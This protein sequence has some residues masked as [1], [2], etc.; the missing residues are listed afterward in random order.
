MKK[1]L[2]LSFILLSAIYVFAQDTAP[3]PLTQAEYV[4]L[5]Y[6]LEKSP[7][8]KDEVIE[9]VRKRGIGFELTDGLRSL[10]ASKS[11]SD[12]D[13]RRTLE[14]AARRKADPVKAQLPSEKEAAEILDK[15]RQATMT[16]VEE[17]PD[18]VVKQLIAR[19]EAYA[20]T[21]NWKRLDNVAIAVSF[22][23]TKGEEYK[24]MAING[25]P[26]NAEKG[27]NYGGLSGSTTRG[28]FVEALEIV[29]KPESK[30]EF[31]F[32]DT[33]VVRGR[34][35]VVYNYKIA[36]ENNKGTNSI[37]LKGTFT[38][39]VRIGRK[40]RI[41]VDRKT[42]RILRLELLATDLPA[43]FDVKS[44]E[45]VIDYDWVEIGG[46]KYLLPISADNKFTTAS[47][48]QLFQDR[49]YIRF[50]DYQKYGSEVRILDD[51]TEIVEEKP[52][53]KN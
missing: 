43:S 7:A 32:V 5:L 34:Q 24:V 33:D 38:P 35:A 3:K 30:T 15:A 11:R 1:V 36:L 37:A 29:F 53:Q 41:W 23:L 9:A 8:K 4:K 22:S 39:A 44:Y 10:T 28:E 21:N 17:M 16:A 18:F 45:S 48:S 51:D 6:A 13:L 2:S 12:A 52:N 26:V 47:G 20:G 40:G 19:S 27:N 14:E 49:N 42:F 50:K 25:T 46:E 31:S